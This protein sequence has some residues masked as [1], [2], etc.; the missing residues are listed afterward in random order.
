VDQLPVGLR[1]LIG[2]EVAVR[3]TV[4]LPSGAVSVMAQVMVKFSLA[5]S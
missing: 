4:D 1:T 3:L 5:L 2:G